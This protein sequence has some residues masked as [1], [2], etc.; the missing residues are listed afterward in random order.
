MISAGMTRFAAPPTAPAPASPL[1]SKAICFWLSGQLMG[2][3]IEHVK[4]T[5]VLRPITR[6]FLTPPW[7]SGLINLRGDIVAVLDLAALLG[8][9]SAGL[10]DESRIVITRHAGRTAGFVA[11]RVAEARAYDHAHL[12]PAPATLGAEAADLLAGLATQPDG[13]PLVIIDLARL[14]GSERLAP[15]SRRT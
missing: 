11:D 4:E 13:A 9:T 14:L 2:V 12:E 15:F 8:M 7:V 5:I 10:T 3:P 6:V 1:A